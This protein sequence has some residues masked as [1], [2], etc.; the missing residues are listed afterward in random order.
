MSVRP[1]YDEIC[2]LYKCVCPLAGVMLYLR[3]TCPKCGQGANHGRKSDFMWPAASILICIIYGP[4]ELSS[5][6][7]NH[8]DLKCNF[9]FHLMVAAPFCNLAWLCDPCCDPYQQISAMATVDK[10]R[11]V[12]FYGSCFQERWKLQF[13]F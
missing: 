2:N 4:P 13:L 7:Q 12:D 8:V 1:S 11:K 9:S 3:Q 10:K 5:R 6:M